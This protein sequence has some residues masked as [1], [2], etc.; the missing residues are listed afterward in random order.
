MTRS[1]PLTLRGCSKHRPGP[2]STDPD[3]NTRCHGNTIT[4]TRTSRSM[5]VS[6]LH[7]AVPPLPR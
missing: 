7:P 2:S 3:R 6:T 5:P 1:Q 4:L